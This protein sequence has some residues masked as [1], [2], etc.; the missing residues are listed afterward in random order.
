MYHTLAAIHNNN[1][2]LERNLFKQA[3]M[4]RKIFFAGFMMVTTMAVAQQKN[5]GDPKPKKA[6][7]K[8]EYDHLGAPMP[9]LWMITLDTM[10]PTKKEN[11]MMKKTPGM[12][13]SADNKR[14]YTD[15]YYDN[16]AN[17]IVM[18][19][20]PTCGHCE[21]QTER[22]IKNIDTFKKS[23]LVLLANPQMKQYLPNFVKNHHIADYPGVI[24]LGYDST[25]FIKNTFLYQ[26]LP[27]INIYSAD[28]KLIRTFSGNVLMDTLV[29]YIQ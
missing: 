21:D 20:N 3:F 9:Q 7:E 24:S 14:M 29:Q 11:K 25:D 10:P 2:Y 16:K 26:A 17:L 12:M 19:F 6:E 1:R 8:I 15:K 28:R 18:M 22:F 5:A 4:I 27:Q 13:R 23:K